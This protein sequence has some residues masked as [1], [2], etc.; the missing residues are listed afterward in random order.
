[1][2][3]DELTDIYGSPYL[4][5][6]NTKQVRGVKVGT[7]ARETILVHEDDTPLEEGKH[8]RYIARPEI[9]DGHPGF[10]PEY[11]VIEEVR[12]AFDINTYF[13]SLDGSPWKVEAFDIKTEYD[14]IF[15]RDRFVIWINRV[16]SQQL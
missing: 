3:T 12:T 10:E 16:K 6:D 14:N 13:L 5:H 8:I 2:T 4:R 11:G 7:T 9:H 1:M 15:F